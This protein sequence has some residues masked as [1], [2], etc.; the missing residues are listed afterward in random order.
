MD[1]NIRPEYSS[2]G[3]KTNQK[4]KYLIAGIIITLILSIAGGAFAF[5]SFY[6]KGNSGISNLYSDRKDDIPQTVGDEK[7]VVE[8]PKPVYVASPINGKIL[9]EKDFNAIKNRPVLAVMIQNNSASRPEYGLNQA[10]VV[11][12][13]LAE[14]GITRFMAVYWSQG[15]D[16]VMSIRSARKYFVDLLGDYATSVYMH[17]GY[18][19]GADNVSAIN[20]LNRYRV[21]DLTNVSGAFQRDHNCERVKAVEHCAYSSTQ[22]LWDLAAKNNWNKDVNL[23][24]PWKF[25]DASAEEDVTA[26]T[27]TDFTTNFQGY[28]LNYSTRW[29]YDPVAKKYKRYNPNGTPYMDGFNKQVETDVVIYQKI[30][31]YPANDVKHHQVQ[32]VIGNGTG[33]VMQEGKAYPVTWKKSNYETRTKFTN[34]ATG[35]EFEF[36]RGNMWIMLVSK[37]NEYTDNTPKPTLTPT[38]NN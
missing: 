25:K 35:K 22:T 7:V 38:V 20:A 4:K 17:I 3:A 21:R 13:T 24:Q 18:S 12:E 30:T 16:K 5:K 23:V 26:K 2:V 28:D 11:Y 19:E 15:S 32:E 10:D 27:V 33:Y 9:E 14:G 6:I 37:A 36:N 1:I 31:S 8:P 29:R 34:T